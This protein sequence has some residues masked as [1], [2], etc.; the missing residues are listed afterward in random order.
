M[1]RP[2]GQLYFYWG[3]FLFS[4]CFFPLY[5]YCFYC[6]PLHLGQPVEKVDVFI[7]RDG[8]AWPGK[9]FHSLESFSARSEAVKWATA[10]LTM[11]L[12]GGDQWDNI[13]EASS[14][15]PMKMH[16][17]LF[18]P[19]GYTQVSGRTVLQIQ[20]CP[21]QYFVLLILPRLVPSQSA[22][23]LLNI[24]KLGVGTDDIVVHGLSQAT[25][26]K[27]GPVCLDVHRQSYPEQ[28][29]CGQP[30]PAPC[31]ISLHIYSESL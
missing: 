19:K 24:T 12:M 14:R 1:M 2:K 8:L 26:S 6:F 27:P 29:G 7:R 13:G 9:N 11:V 23:P 30:D 4:L 5:F 21:S 3:S 28:A 10:T 17:V 15:M 31:F 25:S 16:R 22:W 18:D 20:I